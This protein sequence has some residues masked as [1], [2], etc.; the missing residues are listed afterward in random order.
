V[1]LLTCFSAGPP[2]RDSLWCP[3]PTK[4]PRPISCRAASHSLPTPCALRPPLA[5]VLLHASDHLAP[6]LAGSLATSHIRPSTGQILLCRCAV[7]TASALAPTSVLFQPV[8]RPFAGNLTRCTLLDSN[9]TF[10]VIHTPS[11][12]H[13]SLAHRSGCCACSRGQKHPL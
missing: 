4:L 7:P 10:C 3:A 8:Q 5:P 11:Q 12:A 1:T 9:R 6:P 13:N 2:H